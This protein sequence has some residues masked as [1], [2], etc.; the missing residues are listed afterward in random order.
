VSVPNGTHTRVRNDLFDPHEGFDRGRPTWFFALWYMVKCVFF[1]S[2]LPWPS[3]LKTFLLRCFGARV[4]RNVTFKPRINIHLPWKL[5]VGDHTWVGEEVCII[6]FA[7][8]GI[9]AHCCLSQR[10]TLCSGNHDYQSANMRYR[11]GPIALHDG[12]W[13]GAGAFVGPDVTIGTD[14]VVTAMSLVNH[15]LEGGMVYAGQP[16]T[17]IR[18]RWPDAPSASGP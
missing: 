9:G 18:R 17:A 11:H 8:I 4:G 6:N 7:P 3:R 1:L 15:S 13:V 16:C 12:V 5:V 14:A 2:P 10:S